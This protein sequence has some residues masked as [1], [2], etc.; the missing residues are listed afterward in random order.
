[1]TTHFKLLLKVHS[2]IINIINI[3]NSN[4]N[5]N[6][7]SIIIIILDSQKK[8]SPVHD[9]SNEDMSAIGSEEPLREYHA[10][11]HPFK[12]THI[13]DDHSAITQCI[14]IASATSQKYGNSRFF[15]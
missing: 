4:S 9:S 14:I 7:S 3:S 12:S 13:A 8:S 2:N 6:S 15:R 5:S 10:H 1:M 11:P